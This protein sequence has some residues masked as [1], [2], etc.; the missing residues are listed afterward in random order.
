[1]IRRDDLEQSRP[2]SGA[3][4]QRDW[5]RDV[6]KNRLEIDA[7]ER[8]IQSIEEY[9]V[10]ELGEVTAVGLPRT[11]DK[12]AGSHR[13]VGTDGK[14]LTK[15]KILELEKIGFDVKQWPYVYWKLKGKVMLWETTE[16]LA[17][18]NR[19]LAVAAEDKG[20]KV[21]ELV[22]DDKWI[23]ELGEMLV[24]RDGKDLKDWCD[25][26]RPVRVSTGSKPISTKRQR[27][28]NLVIQ[29]PRMEAQELWPVV[30]RGGTLFAGTERVCQAQEIEAVTDDPEGLERLREIIRRYVKRGVPTRTQFGEKSEGCE[31]CRVIPG[32]LIDGFVEEVETFMR[33]NIRRG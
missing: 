21:E 31:E 5:E 16:E 11:F 9:L 17:M 27:K 3:V 1:M 32:D 19:V 29:T 15:K 10:R 7:S 13:L 33:R 12:W 4:A 28:T 14:P 18:L 23:A 24:D 30:E 8:W 6:V 26:Y 25:G 22:Q 2:S 20:R